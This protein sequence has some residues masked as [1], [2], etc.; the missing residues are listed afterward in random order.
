MRKRKNNNFKSNKK[1]YSITTEIRDKIWLLWL[2]RCLYHFQRHM[3]IIWYQ[4][5]NAL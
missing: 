2:K 5:S 3:Y 1:K 4:L